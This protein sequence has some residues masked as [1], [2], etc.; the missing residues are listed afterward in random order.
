MER[1][2]YSLRECVVFA[3]LLQLP[4]FRNSNA[5]AHSG[6][7]SPLPIAVRA[8]IFWREEFSFFSPRRLASTCAYRRYALSA[9]LL[10]L[11]TVAWARPRF[12]RLR[13]ARPRFA[14]PR[15]ARPPFARLSTWHGPALALQDLALQDL[16]LRDYRRAD[17]LASTLRHEYL[18]YDALG[19]GIRNTRNTRT[20]FD[21][22]YLFLRGR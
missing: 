9:S 11:P 15:F 4:P 7:F 22:L 18:L 8:F 14:R 21:W 2:L 13:F 6:H 12:A 3:L 20:E 16:A 17:A 19:S 5:E 10:F 1:S